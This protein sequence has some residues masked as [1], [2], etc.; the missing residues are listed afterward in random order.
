MEKDEN[1]DLSR[2]IVE[3][4]LLVI[5][6]AIGCVGNLMCI[7]I[8][9]QKFAQKSFH[10]LMLSLAI[11]DLLYVLMSI[12]LF[13]LPTL[14][15]EVR[16]VAWYA[17]LVPVMLPM[18]QVGLTG[19]IYLTVAISIE[20]YATVV[21]PFFKMSH[22]WSSFNYI[23]PVAAFSIIYN[24]PKFF[25]LTTETRM[26]TKV[27][28]I[29]SPT[30]LYNLTEVSEFQSLKTSVEMTVVVA[31]NLRQNPYYVQ[32]Y[33]VYMN[34]LLNGLIPLVSLVILNTL[35]YLRL[36]EFSQCVEASKRNQSVQSREVM[37]A[38]I[39]CL[40]VAVFIV[41]HSIRWIPNI[42]E[43]Q[44]GASRKED[45]VWPPW[46][47][48]TIHLSHLLT[49]INS[50]VNFYIYFLKHHKGHIFRG[51]LPK[52]WFGPARGSDAF[53]SQNG[54]TVLT[55]TRGNSKKTQLFLQDGK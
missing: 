10:H 13:G 8:F 23:L 3:G 54:D 50:S 7:I 11:F 33:V 53:C 48:Y 16:Q 38:K 34:L 12:M 31:T 9:S 46:V 35:V 39:S 51:F 4:V 49:V 28:N 43:L 42:F 30:N 20:R 6:G 27:T 25:E 47:Q 52:G 14:Y 26:F 55:N 40:I 1:L 41:C 17:Y 32:I 2:Y 24:I 5:F 45:L 36:R 15:P 29:S 19:S 22:S 37:L 44:Q 21:H 18:A